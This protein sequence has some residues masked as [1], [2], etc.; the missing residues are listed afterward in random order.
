MNPI[1]SVLMQ[2]LQTINPQGYQFAN[3]LMQNNGDPEGALKQMLSKI[4]PEQRQQVLN[5]AKSYGCPTDV[6]SKIQ[7]MK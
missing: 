2:R 3:Q 1:M 6:L 4:S 7:N 5:T